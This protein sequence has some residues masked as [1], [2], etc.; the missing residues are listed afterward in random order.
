MCPRC[1]GRYCSGQQRS[2][3]GPDSDVI[4]SMA[5]F[6]ESCLSLSSLRNFP[7]PGTGS[8]IFVVF[9]PNKWHGV[10][11]RMR[12]MSLRVRVYVWR[13][14]MPCLM[15]SVAAFWPRSAGL[16]LGVGLVVY[17]VALGQHLLSILLLP[18]GSIIQPLLKTHLCICQKRC[19]V[20]AI[21]SVVTLSTLRL[22]GANYW[23]VRALSTFSSS[24][25]PTADTWRAHGSSFATL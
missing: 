19:T 17:G 16:R 14:A 3:D 11:S 10:T 8:V 9:L 1:Q 22:T 2:N 23:H 25:T 5:P 13:D 12:T 6:I 15:R 20:L 4:T 24:P 7:R 18:P 21:Q